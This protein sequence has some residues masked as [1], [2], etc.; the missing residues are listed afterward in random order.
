MKDFNL[1]TDSRTLMIAGGA[2]VI[3]I[4]YVWLADPWGVLGGLLFGALTG[5]TVAGGAGLYQIL[6]ANKT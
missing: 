6:F 3:L 1:P 4:V 5:A 2:L